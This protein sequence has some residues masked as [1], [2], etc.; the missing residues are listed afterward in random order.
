MRF[1]KIGRRRFTAMVSW[2][3]KQAKE[4][5]NIKEK[6]QIDDQLIIIAT[7]AF[8]TALKSSFRKSGKENWN[9]FIYIYNYGY[10]DKRKIRREI[11]RLFLEKIRN[12][13]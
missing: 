3:R 7:N 10:F 4:Q 8:F 13:G 1:N 5:L 12:R 2:K 9:Q 6:M 11:L